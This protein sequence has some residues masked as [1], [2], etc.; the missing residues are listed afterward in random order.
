MGVEGDIGEGLLA[1][2]AYALL[3]VTNQIEDVTLL[4]LRNPWG[5]GE[6]TGKWGDSWD[7]WEKNPRYREALRYKN[8]DDG[9]FWM[10]L[11]L[12]TN[13]RLH[14]RT[15]ERMHVHMHHTALQHTAHDVCVACTATA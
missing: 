4:K 2:H 6:W 15:N 8:E 14:A 9:T 7:G 11:V 10:D 1:N 13:T 5:H 3:N 12:C